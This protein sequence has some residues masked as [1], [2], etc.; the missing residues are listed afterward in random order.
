[1]SAVDID[2]YI[3]YD[4]FY[5]QY[6]EHIDG[7]GDER[8]ARCPFHRD[9]NPSF[10]FN[11]KSGKWKCFYGCGCGNAQTFYAK[12]K[13][14][15]PKT[16][17]KELLEQYVPE[18]VRK[19]SKPAAPED[20]PYSLAEYSLSKHLPV[21]FLEGLGL[22]NAGAT[23][24]SIPYRDAS[25]NIVS[26]RY[27]Y[28][29]GSKQRFSWARGS[30][31]M[32]YALDHISGAER[33]CLCEGESDTQ[34]LLYHDVCAV[35]LPGASVPSEAVLEPLTGVPEIVIVVDDDPPNKDTGKR[36][37]EECFTKVCSVLHAMKYS[38][39]VRR[40]TARL[41]ADD[42][43]D[44]SDIHVKH[45]DSAHQ[46][47][48]DMID[49]AEPVTLSA[50]VESDRV[51]RRAELSDP[52]LP[53]L[54][55]PE[56]YAVTDAGVS[57]TPDRG[58]PVVIASV[59]FIVSG[60]L[61]DCDGSGEWLEVSLR[62][63]KGKWKSVSVRRTE[64][65]SSQGILKSAL[66]S[67]GCPG[68]TSA[69]ASQACC[70]L[71]AFESANRDIIPTVRRISHY[72]W[73]PDG[74]FFCGQTIPGTVF[75]P[76]GAMPQPVRTCGTLEEWQSTVGSLLIANPLALFITCCSLAAPLLR[77]C[78]ARSFVVYNWGDSGGGKSAAL[79]AALSVWGYPRDM[80]PVSLNATQVAIE[81][82]ASHFCD[83]PMG[84]DERQTVQGKLAQ[85]KLESLVYMLCEERGKGRGSKDGGLRQTR[86]WK[87][88]ALL[89]G[90]Q[91]LAQSNTMTGVYGRTLEIYGVPFATKEQ[92]GSVYDLVE[93][94]YGTAGQKWIEVIQSVGEEELRSFYNTIKASLLKRFPRHNPSNI[95][96]VALAFTAWKYAQKTVFGLD[97]ASDD[98]EEQEEMKKYRG[99]IY[100]RMEDAILGQ[101]GLPLNADADVVD[102]AAEFLNGYVQAN[103]GHFVLDLDER[104][105]RYGYVNRKGEDDDFS[106]VWF[107]KPKLEQILSQAG[108]DLKKVM[109][110]L[111]KDGRWEK[112]E[113]VSH[114][115]RRTTH[116]VVKRF[117]G[118]RV[119]V[120]ALHLMDEP[121]GGSEGEPERR[122]NREDDARRA[123]VEGNDA[124]RATQEGF[125]EVEDSDLP[126]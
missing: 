78:R 86:T 105:E 85:E 112:G 63:Y 92:A 3:N 123:E 26:T 107:I 36:P 56:G 59:P 21:E 87:T 19:S 97:C 38:G 75:S 60:V 8:K 72:G 18:S 37:G 115:T 111:E 71:A 22:R 9:T 89:N 54:I 65:V 76:E 47:I 6:L 30:N 104:M 14:L 113:E 13:N 77:P 124:R 88:V 118:V 116:D 98:P 15:D 40:T 33:V 67:A 83:L 64:A 95:A 7:T 10:S 41:V 90:E 82:A 101:G 58:D 80:Q 51:A 44:P 11:V 119:R 55:I 16:A 34:T 73:Q 106:T 125:L 120:Y 121:S 31:V 50:V 53:G 1:M 24:I 68:L 66:V 52:P 110:G 122:E 49:R 17:Y 94:R 69:T 61:G 81:V 32:L 42:C 25:G 70:Y 27:R 84:A 35:G 46:L 48:L 43:K 114:G 20:L 93:E 96:C 62:D 57:Y 91:A 5:R 108:F 28:H 103:R 2:R 12:L 126:F 79:T 23:R 39:I 29:P 117:C 99:E 4:E 109:L 74:T 45:S 102:H 100:Q